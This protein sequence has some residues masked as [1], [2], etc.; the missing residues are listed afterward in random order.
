[1]NNDEINQLELFGYDPKDKENAIERS[2]ESKKKQAEFKKKLREQKSREEAELAKKKWEEVSQQRI[3]EQNEIVSEVAQF[4]RYRIEKNPV[5]LNEHFK[6]SEIAAAM[7]FL[8]QTSSHLVNYN[9][10]MADTLNYFNKNGELKIPSEPNK[11]NIKF[12]EYDPMNGLPYLYEYSE[13]EYN[14]KEKHWEES[15][16]C[17][18]HPKTKEAFYGYPF[19]LT[20]FYQSI[21]NEVIYTAVIDE[22]VSLNYDQYDDEK[23]LNR[24]KLFIKLFYPNQY[25]IILKSI[26][27]IFVDE[28]KINIEASKSKNKLQIKINHIMNYHAGESYE[29]EEVFIEALYQGVI[30]SALGKFNHRTPKKLHIHLY[31]K[32]S[33]ISSAKLALS[34]RWN[35][36]RTVNFEK[37]KG[38]ENRET[39]DEFQTRREELIKLIHDGALGKFSYSCKKNYFQITWHHPDFFVPNSIDEIQ[40]DSEG[41]FYD[42]LNSYEGPRWII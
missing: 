10:N 27:E 35:D 31:Q 13:I 21:F 4:G 12:S 40:D 38:Y 22:G 30:F 14:E 34:M 28:K 42:L 18:I 9:I 1:M 25:K 20:N 39:I 15:D 11:S 41:I 19:N 37:R 24:I 32:P 2:K 33:I 3:K 23:N 26:Q 5:E 8:V 6:D 17:P 36:P 29:R 7:Y 16:F